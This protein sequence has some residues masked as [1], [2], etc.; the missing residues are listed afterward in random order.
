[1]AARFC[2]IQNA[3]K[4]FVPL[5]ERCQIASKF[6]PSQ[7]TC[8]ERPAESQVNR[9]PSAASHIWNMNA[10]NMSTRLIMW[11]WSNSR[12]SIYAWHEP[13]CILN[14]SYFS[15]FF[16]I[17]IFLTHI[18]PEAPLWYVTRES[19]SDAWYFI[20]SSVAIESIPISIYYRFHGPVYL[21]SPTPAWAHISHRCSRK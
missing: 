21:G 2:Q 5:S 20:L 15:P 8:I 11:W 12:P 13:A 19:A 16:R 4:L 3:E 14:Y 18:P 1:M 17:A 7:V 6:L 9:Y 10:D